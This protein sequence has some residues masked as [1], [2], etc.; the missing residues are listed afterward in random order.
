MAAAIVA[1]VYA[2]A[3][4]GVS[5]VW[6]RARVDR[7][8]VRMRP[9]ALPGEVAFARG[10]RLLISRGAYRRQDPSRGDV[11]LARVDGVLAIQRVIALPGDVMLTSG[12]A[13]YLNESELAA[14]RYPLH[15]QIA[16]DDRV[17]VPLGLYSVPVRPG[18]FLVWGMRGERDGMQIGPRLIE[19]RHIIGKAWLVYTP[20]RNRRVIDHLDPVLKQGGDDGTAGD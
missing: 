17:Q 19:R 9:D 7:A 12:G 5:A 20:Y 15:P 18:Q 4:W 3:I 14:E 6:E 2:V 10:D 1:G 11:I 16:R 13:I 8:V